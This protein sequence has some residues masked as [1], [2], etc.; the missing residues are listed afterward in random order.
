MFKKALPVLIIVTALVVA[1]LL[2]LVR[3]EAEQNEPQQLLVV[4]DAIE[5][6]VQDTY[7]TVPSQGTVEPRTRTNL[8]SE[9]SGQVVEVSPAFVAWFA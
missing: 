8:V 6:V 4:V 2:R 3:P 7:I 5:V 1:G 9:V